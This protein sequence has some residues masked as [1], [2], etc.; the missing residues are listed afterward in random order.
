LSRIRSDPGSENFYIQIWQRIYERRFADAIAMI[1]DAIAS[2][3]LPLYVKAIYDSTLADVKQFS[4]DTDGA[5]I[6]WQQVR[7]EVESLRQQTNGE[8]LALAAAYAALGDQRKALA[9]VDQMPVDAISVGG[10]ACLR[11]RIA[12]YAGNKDSVIEQLATAT[13]NPV[14]GG[15]GYCATYGDLKFKPVWDPLRGDPR[16]EKIVASLA[17]KPAD[18]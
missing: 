6:A 7:D 9:I 18:K 3:D 8:R 10:L 12:V 1:R 2:R 15:P 4:R 11:A 5:R 14:S 16:F 17:P 13:H